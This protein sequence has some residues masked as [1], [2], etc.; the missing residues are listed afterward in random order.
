M[1]LGIFKEE[2]GK[3]A[4]LKSKHVDV[5]NKHRILSNRNVNL[6][7]TSSKTLTKRKW[8]L[9]KQLVIQVPKRMISQNRRLA[10]RNIKAIDDDMLS[11]ST[12]F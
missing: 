6:S 11:T 4:D 12:S 3:H 9:S 2:I 10:M 7:G 1:D 8:D 5:S